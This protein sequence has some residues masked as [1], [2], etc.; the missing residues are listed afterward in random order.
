M[1]CVSLVKFKKKKDLFL[2]AGYVLLICP[3]IKSISFKLHLLK[4]MHVKFNK[5]EMR[6]KL[7]FFKLE[8]IVSTKG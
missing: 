8:W 6:R 3:C 4:S 5:V 2:F 1:S 7:L